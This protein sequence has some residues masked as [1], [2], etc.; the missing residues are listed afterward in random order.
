MTFVF[1]VLWLGL[2][3]SADTPGREPS[4]APPPSPRRPVPLYTNEDLERVHPLRDETGVNSTPATP[5]ASA[6][7]PASRPL[8][9]GESFWRRE[10]ARVRARIRALADDAETVRHKL[11]ERREERRRFLRP[12]GSGVSE[13]TLLARLEALQ[14]RMRELE[15]DLEERAR[16]D[17]ALPGWLR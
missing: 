5:P 7:G 11:E 4:P 9:R 8:S 15:T 3:P 14:R 10:A 2:C 17:R 6:T 1:V 16:R 13:A 12:R